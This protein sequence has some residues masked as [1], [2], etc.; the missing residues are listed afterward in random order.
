M[1]RNTND[2]DLSS[3]RQNLLL[4]QNLKGDFQVGNCYRENGPLR[5]RPRERERDMNIRAKLET[6]YATIKTIHTLQENFLM[7][8]MINLHVSVLNGKKV[9][10]KSSSF[11]VLFQGCSCEVGAQE[12]SVI[13]TKSTHIFLKANNRWIS[14]LSFAWR[15]LKWRH[16]ILGKS[17]NNFFFWPCWICLL[18]SFFKPNQLDESNNYILPNKSNAFFH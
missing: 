1:L 8:D 14:Q 18:R 6:I 3:W 11:A 15:W 13:T 9:S 17:E 5:G 4:L 7:F 12:R 2:H 16:F 10:L